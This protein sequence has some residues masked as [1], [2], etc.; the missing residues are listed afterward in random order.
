MIKNFP[1]LAIILL[2]KS[3]P[4]RERT[5]ERFAFLFNP[6]E[7]WVRM[8]EALKNK[9]RTKPIG[10]RPLFRKSVSNDLALSTYDQHA[11]LIQ[12]CEKMAEITYMGL[13]QGQNVFENLILNA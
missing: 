3:K 8:A 12:I 7:R 5:P 4:S 11:N 9:G 6:A 1:F 2:Y 10:I 13:G